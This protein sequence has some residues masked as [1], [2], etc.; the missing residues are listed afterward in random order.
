MSDKFKQI[1]YL[2]LSIILLILIIYSIKNNY[3]ISYVLLIICPINL[4]AIIKSK[5]TAYFRLFF[6]LIG[7]FIGFHGLYRFAN[8]LIDKFS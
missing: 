3:E 4:I 7:I 1:I 6:N 8:Q 2:I 5:K